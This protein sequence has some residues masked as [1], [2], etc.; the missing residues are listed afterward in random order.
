MLRRANVVDA[1]ALGFVELVAG[2][3][4]YL[5]T[6]VAPADDAAIQLLSDDEATAG[7]QMDLE[8]RWCTECTITGEAS[9]AAACARRRPRSARA[10]SSPAAQNKVR[11]HI[12]TNEPPQAVRAR[13]P[14][15][16]GRRRESRR[17]AAAAGDGAPRRAAARRGRHGFRG[18]PAGVGARG[19]RHPRGAGARALRHAELPRQGRA[20]LRGVLPHARVES[21]APEDLAA[22]ARRFPARLRVPRLA[23][24]RRRVRRPDGARLRHV[25]ERRDGGLARAHARAHPD[26]RFR[27][28]RARPGA[29]RDARGRGRGRGRRRRGRARGRG[30]GRRARRAPGAASSRSSSPCAAGACRPGSS[31]S[32]TRSAW[33]RS[34]WCSRAAAS[35]SAACCSGGTNPYRRYGKLLRRR[36]DPARHWRIGISHANVPDGAAAVREVLAAGL[37]RAEFLPIIPLGTALG[38]HGGPG[39]IVVAAQELQRGRTF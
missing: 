28:G 12:H 32:P 16:H 27:H 33:C 22:A 29:D 2:M 9:T 7:S 5:E 23:L 31:R 1:G 18:R 14:L 17:H 39:C 35:A 8:H 21:R 38:V 4:D 11:L 37:P 3:T 34:S 24:R 25:P 26:A 10:W 36:L 6:G 19:A 13:R 20:V 30:R 15:R